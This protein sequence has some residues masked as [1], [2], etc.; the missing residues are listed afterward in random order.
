MKKN[1]WVMDSTPKQL[2]RIIRIQ[3]MQIEDMQQTASDNG[4]NKLVNEL[5][6]GVS[7][8]GKWLQKVKNGVITPTDRNTIRMEL[9]HYLRLC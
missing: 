8:L 6:N 1:Y 5:E 2:E 9:K 3:L 4:N 7:E